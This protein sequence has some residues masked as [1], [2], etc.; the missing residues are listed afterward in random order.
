M[1]M[2][3]PGNAAGNEA[4][5][6]DPARCDRTALT[7]NL[8]ALLTLDDRRQSRYSRHDQQRPTLPPPATLVPGLALDVQARRR[9]SLRSMAC[10]GL[11]GATKQASP[12]TDLPSRG[13]CVAASA[14]VGWLQAAWSLIVQLRMGLR[15][16]LA[17][18][19]SVA[20][21]ERS[22]LSSAH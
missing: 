6:R 1:V 20:V 12:G 4:L 11:A 5:S 16:R 7:R 13:L 19:S 22:S 2:S 3:T 18:R 17:I 10:R 21:D 9:Q 8:P 15:C 14:Q